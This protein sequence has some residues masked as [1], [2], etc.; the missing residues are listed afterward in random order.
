MPSFP[1]AEPTVSYFDDLDYFKDFEKELSAVAYSDALTSKLDFLTE[2]TTLL[3]GRESL[4]MKDVL[5]TLNSR[6]LKKRTEGTKKETSDGLYGRLKRDC[7]MKKSSGFIKKGKRDQDSD[8]SNDEGNAYFGEALVLVENDEMIELVMDS[9]GSYHMTH[10]R[11]FL[12]DFKDIDGGLVK[13]GDN[14]TCTIKETGKVKIQLHDG[15]SFI[16]EDVRIK[17]IKG[18]VMM[19]GIKKNNCVYSLEAKVMTFGVQKHGGVYGVQ[20]DK[21]VW[22]EVE[23]QRALGNREAEVFQVSND[24]VVMTQRWLEDK[25]LEEK[26]NMDCLVKEQEKENYR[27]T[28]IGQQGGLQFEVPTLEKDAEYRLCLT[29]TPKVEIVGY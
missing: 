3:Y 28:M 16:L 26:T 27:S 22:F 20:V 1:S 9:G 5:A 13:L 24:D 12:Y 23:L 25:Q 15:S 10:R 17:V 29:V 18:W 7:P 21:R 14:R 19:N 6:E 11:D 8:S 4:T 2:P